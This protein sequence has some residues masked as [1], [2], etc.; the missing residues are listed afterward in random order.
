MKEVQLSK[1]L[2]SGNAVYF[3][4]C[5]NA[6]TLSWD[7]NLNTYSIV[8]TILVWIIY[9]MKNSFKVKN[10][11]RKE[12]FIHT[13]PFVIAVIGLFYTENID[14]GIKYISRLI[15]FVVFP[16][17]FSSV[18]FSDKKYTNI[19]IV[20]VVGCLLYN[21]YLW[22]GFFEYD[23]KL[24][25]N[26]F[27]R[28]GIL[29]RFN[30]FI[31]DQDKDNHPTYFS[32]FLILNFFTSIYIII[33]NKSKPKIIVIFSFVIIFITLFLFS[34]TAKMP[35]ASAMLI[36]VVMPLIYFIK[37]FKKKAF[38]IYLSSIL[39]VIIIGAGFLKDVPN[40]AVQEAYNYYN[41]FLG[42]ELKP[43]YS[44][45][46]FSVNY[47]TFWWEK[48]NRIVIWKNS[49]E[50]MKRSPII[51]FGTG[52]VQDKLTEVYKENKE[53]WRMQFFNSHNQY[54]DYQ[55]RYG[56]LGVGLLFY[57]LY[58]YFRR[59][60]VNSDYL[61]VSFIILVSLCLLTENLFQR[62]WGIIYFAF[63]NALFYYR[64]VI[65]KKD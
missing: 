10:F 14:Y 65:I 32:L 34:L 44:Y 51:G 15:G 43:F 40:R 54:I 62:H 2:I 36:M 30:E 41:Y 53:L 47:D 19:L 23:I 18:K 27:F 29:L 12:V 60:I 56:V 9:L 52:D 13:F 42:N 28:K 21:F 7:L 59:A 11:K 5:L 24:F 20:F 6:L 49:F 45:K 3:F 57:M 22:F 26:S 63:F 1:S 31:S 48:T 35:I 37:N 55:L 64:K 38:V 50:L 25:I 4:L 33:K 61:Y 8:A 46:E 39:M 58:F 17:I 16:L